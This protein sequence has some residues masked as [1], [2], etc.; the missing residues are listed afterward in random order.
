LLIRTHQIEEFFLEQNQSVYNLRLIMTELTTRINMEGD[1][2]RYHTLYAEQ[3]IEDLQSNL[4]KGLST[5]EAVKRLEHYGLNE[6]SKPETESIWE[7][8]KEQFSDLLVRIL[9]FAA[10]LSFAISLTGKIHFLSINS[11][12]S[13]KSNIQ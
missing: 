2:K 4:D 13:F 9:L 12:F 6:L 8:I 11:L 10:F 7:K 3:V 1:S 5:K